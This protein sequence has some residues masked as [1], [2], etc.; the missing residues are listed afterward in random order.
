MASEIHPHS[1]KL[2]FGWM[3]S[4]TEENPDR[5]RPEVLIQVQAIGA[6]QNTW[7]RYR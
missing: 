3:I 1:E 4:F 7:R 2:P 5:L 6:K